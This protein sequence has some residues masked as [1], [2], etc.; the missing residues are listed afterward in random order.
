MSS[1]PITSAVAHIDTVYSKGTIDKK[2]VSIKAPLFAA[3]QDA[4]SEFLNY[5]VAENTGYAISLIQAI[6]TQPSSMKRE[7]SSNA[8]DVMHK[9]RDTFLD[10]KLPDELRK[11]AKI[12][13]RD[14]LLNVSPQEIS[15]LPIEKLVLADNKKDVLVAAGALFKVIG[16][17]GASDKGRDIEANIDH[18]LSKA[19]DDPILNKVLLLDKGKGY[20]PK[21]QEF[22]K[23]VV[24]SELLDILDDSEKILVGNEYADFR[25]E[26]NS[27]E[28]V[29][30]L[31]TVLAHKFQAAIPKEAKDKRMIKPEYVI[32]ANMAELVKHVPGS[33]GYIKA[34]QALLKSVNDSADRQFVLE[35]AIANINQ[36][37]QERQEKIEAGL[38][39]VF[40]HQD[41]ITNLRETLGD[42]TRKHNIELTIRNKQAD[43]IE[44]TWSKMESLI[45]S[46]VLQ[47]SLQNELLHGKV[48]GERQVSE[49]AVKSLFPKEEWAALTDTTISVKEIISAYNES[50]NSGYPNDITIKLHGPTQASDETTEV[51]YSLNSAQGHVI[52]QLVRDDAKYSEVKTEKQAELMQL[53]KERTWLEGKL[54]GHT[55]LTDLINMPHLNPRS[56]NKDLTKLAEAGN[57]YA[58]ELSDSIIASAGRFQD[59]VSKLDEIPQNL[60]FGNIIEDLKKGD[61]QRSDIIGIVSELEKNIIDSPNSM[62]DDDRKRFSEIIEILKEDREACSN[63]RVLIHKVHLYEVSKRKPLSDEDFNLSLARDEITLKSSAEEDYERQQAAGSL[64]SKVAKSAGGIAGGFVG[65][66]AGGVVWVFDKSAG[67]SVE[68]GVRRVVGGFVE[69]KAKAVYEHLTYNE[70]HERGK[71]YDETQTGIADLVRYEEL[72]H[73]I[74]TLRGELDNLDSSHSLALESKRQA[75]VNNSMLRSSEIKVDYLVVMGLTNPERADEQLLQP[76]ATVIQHS[77]RENYS[78]SG[79]VDVMKAL[80]AYVMEFAGSLMSSYQGTSIAE[81]Q[82]NLETRLLP[83]A[84]IQEAQIVPRELVAQ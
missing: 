36:R 19:L 17:L 49:E 15:Q 44:R 84:P 25:R 7:L 48:N 41:K 16:D 47:E 46:R 61:Y 13:L 70:T 73:Q 32:L 35:D 65:K 55:Q 1:A 83:P 10:E 37:I 11:C 59:I 6:Q 66:M 12:A 58:A 77:M 50:K 79:F 51:T 42:L 3:A 57:S 27:H 69:K 20:D 80:M 60:R 54:F 72:E 62:T 18:I 2:A 56:L 82:Q 5:N 4:A 8:V 52:E 38:G 76:L 67:R 74:N 31:Q 21:L 33:S 71:R 26:L 29:E 68:S 63:E 30:N 24:K 64:S 53:E 23:T 22:Y 39:R 78:T 43:L 45:G 75:Y 81:N 14:I 40:D 34:K 28:L 9:L